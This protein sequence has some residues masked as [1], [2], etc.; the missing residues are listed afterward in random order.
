MYDNYD[1]FA[2]CEDCHSKDKV[3]ALLEKAIEMQKRTIRAQ[4]ETV[5]SYEIACEEWKFAYEMAKAEL[6]TKVEFS[7][8]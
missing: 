3:I 7:L 1:N 4:E 5:A 6:S 2:I 8:N